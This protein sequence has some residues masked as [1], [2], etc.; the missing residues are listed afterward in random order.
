[1]KIIIQETVNNTVVEVVYQTTVVSIKDNVSFLELV[2]VMDS[3]YTGKDGYVPIVNETTGKLELKAPTGGLSGNVSADNVTETLSRVFVTP[4]E[5]TAIT[6]SNRTI[7][8]AITE[9][10]T[11]TLKTAYDSAVAWISTNGANVI[12]AYTWIQTNGSALLS[13]LSN[14]SNPHNTTASQVGLGNVNNTSDLNKPI[15][16]ATQTALEGKENKT[17]SFFLTA[18]YPLQSSPPITALQSIMGQTH[19]VVAGT[20]R[21]KVRFAGSGFANS[22]SIQFGML[23]TAP[24]TRTA[25]D[26]NANKVTSFPTTNQIIVSSITNGQSITSASAGTLA[27]GLIEGL[28]TFSGSGTFILAIGMSTA[29]AA[30]INTGTI[31][32]TKIN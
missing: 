17:E 1:M 14:T 9:A 11:T 7:L 23:G 12:S 19:D 18:A 30:S 3:S 27:Q 32:L 21:F 13:H 15:S 20:Y 28:V 25:W 2:D 4:P 10:F 24:I 6:H 29:A 26:S 5:K 16:N 22:G 8:D 31:E